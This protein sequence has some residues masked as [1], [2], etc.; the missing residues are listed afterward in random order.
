[1]EIPVASPRDR[2]FTARPTDNPKEFSKLLDDWWEA[3][4]NHYQQVFRS[5]QY[6]AVVDNYLTATWARRL[7]RQMPEPQRYLFQRI[8]LTEPWLSQLLANEEYQTQVERDL[9]LGHFADDDAATIPLPKQVTG[10]LASAGGASPTR[11]PKTPP[12]ASPTDLP[13][14]ASALPATIEP[15]ATHVPH[16]CFYLRFGNFPNYLWYRDF[17]RHWQGDLGNMLVNQSVDHNNS[18]R[19]Q[20]QIA[21]GETKIARVMG[22]TVVHD[23]AIIGIDHYMSDG[24]AMG[25]LFY[26]NNSTLLNRNLSSQRQE[27]KGKLKDAVEET[28]RIANHDVSFIHTPDGRLREP[29]FLRLRPDLT[30][31]TAMTGPNAVL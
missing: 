23:V 7:N 4:E 15:L 11:T 30:F 26:A 1:V 17:T 24:A 25:I 12:P 19:F 18:E 6:P 9:L 29:V 3:T 27:A 14:P 5:A 10:E 22:P 8:R 2:K 16:E 20:Q 13:A 28:I 31:Q 21:V